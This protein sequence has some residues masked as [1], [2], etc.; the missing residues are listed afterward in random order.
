MDAMEFDALRKSQKHFFNTATSTTKINNA[1]IL[2]MHKYFLGRLYTWGGC[3]R[4]VNLS[5]RGFVWPPAKFV[6]Q[7]MAM[8]GRDSAH[9]PGQGLW[10]DF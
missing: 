7:N 6:G 2:D 5:K 9:S 10:P 1:F 3:Y 4:T 8:F